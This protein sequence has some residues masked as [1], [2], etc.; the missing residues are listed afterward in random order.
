LKI[1]IIYK[2]I[3]FI[4]LILLIFKV[5]EMIKSSVLILSVNFKKCI[6]CSQIFND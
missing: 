6:I 2:N 1:K 3:G 4:K 5:R